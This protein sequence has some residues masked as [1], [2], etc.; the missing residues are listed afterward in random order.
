MIYEEFELNDIDLEIEEKINLL[1][2]P[3]QKDLA[4]KNWNFQEIIQSII[5]SKLLDLINNEYKGEK[6]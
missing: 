4:C 5:K 6:V 2:K 3:L 1:E